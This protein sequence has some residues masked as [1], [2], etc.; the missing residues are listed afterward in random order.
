MTIAQLIEKAIESRDVCY[1]DVAKSIGM[2]AQNFYMRRKRNTFS[3]KEIDGIMRF[4]GAKM[5]SYIEFEDGKRIFASAENTPT[6]VQITDNNISMDKKIRMAAAYKDMTQG[7]LA[8]TI[9]MPETEFE[10]KMR[11]KSFSNVELQSMAHALGAIFSP[12]ISFSFT[13]SDGTKI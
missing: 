12:A 11:T 8:E 1:S 3:Q 13:F 9:G 6:S 4:L 2:T 5:V 10:E 7:Q